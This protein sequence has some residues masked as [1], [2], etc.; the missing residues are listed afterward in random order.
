MQ[1]AINIVD[2][3]A[4]PGVAILSALALRAL[5]R[6]R[7][8]LRGTTLLSP[9]RWTLGG[10]FAWTVLPLAQLMV[11]QVFSNWT[12]QLSYACCVL[13]LCPFIAVLGSRRPTDRVWNWFVVL[14]LILVLEWPALTALGNFPTLRTLE[15]QTPV[16]WGFGVVGV[17]GMGNYLGTR[18]GVAAIVATTAIVPALLPLTDP[19]QFGAWLPAKLSP[20]LYP[21]AILLASRQAQRETI[22]ANGPDRV[23]TDFRETFGLVW[24][25]RIQERINAVAQREGWCARLE[26]DGFV[27]NES[28]SDT[29]RRET[30]QRIEHTLRW[31]LRRFVDPG[32]IGMRLC[33]D[34]SGKPPVK[35]FQ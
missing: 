1:S 16:L 3:G 15:I 7:H 13:T 26:P 30:G 18:Y 9:W 28:A 17:M 25:V 35:S 21:A 11:P 20:L 6:V 32:W 12:A 33:T 27:W 5:V 14:P 31:L 34:V 23:W 29:A 8:P 19:E 24:S 22:V 4:A 2:Y 10:L